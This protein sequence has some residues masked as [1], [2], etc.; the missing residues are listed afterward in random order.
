MSIEDNKK[1]AGRFWDLFH[2]DGMQL[3]DEIISDDF[4]HHSW[5]WVGP[6]IDG[7]RDLVANL[8]S[9]FSQYHYDIEDVIAEGDKVVVR[10]S[11]PSDSSSGPTLSPPPVTWD[12]VGRSAGQT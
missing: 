10:L 5:P 9:G 2:D 7:L 8:T 6:G 11:E 3:V 1:L 12:R 4:V